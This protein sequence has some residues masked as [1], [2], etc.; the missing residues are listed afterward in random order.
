MNQV[1]QYEIDV[2]K[3]F[4]FSIFLVSVNTCH[5]MSF[6]A[7]GDRMVFSIVLVNLVKL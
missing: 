6:F 3:L 5:V 4:I 1:S 7:T 2:Y